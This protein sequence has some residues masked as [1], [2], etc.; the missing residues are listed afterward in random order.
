M[1]KRISLKGFIEDVKNELREATDN[2][3]HFFTL[4]T[5]EL[6]V[7]FGLDTKAKVG[8]RLF[9]IDFGGEEKA[10]QT[11]K[12]KLVLTPL[13]EDIDTKPV[14]NSGENSTSGG[15]KITKKGGR[16]MK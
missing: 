9:V 10:S 1:T 16:R 14:E 5:V 7:T 2:D 15:G 8:A 12:V 11:H 3:E 6:E 4:D 13:P